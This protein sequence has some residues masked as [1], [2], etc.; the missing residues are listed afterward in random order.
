MDK[1]FESLSAFIDRFLL[2]LVLLFA[3]LLYKKFGSLFMPDKKEEEQKQANEASHNNALLPDYKDNTKAKTKQEKWS[4][5]IANGKKAK[6][7]KQALYSERIRACTEFGFDFSRV[8]KLNTLAA[9]MKKHKV[10]LSG[11]AEQYKKMSGEDMYKDLRVV[12]GND[13][14]KWLAVAGSTK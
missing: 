13:Y 6:L 7:Y 9:D 8:S 14:T 10:S 11:T 1:F 2:P 4:I 5:D 12:L 3:F